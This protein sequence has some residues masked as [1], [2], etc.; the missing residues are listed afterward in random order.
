MTILVKKALRPSAAAAA[1]AEEEPPL[2]LLLHG[3]PDDAS[4]FHA[5]L[6]PFA[7]AGFDVVVP[8]MPGYEPSTALLPPS[9]Y[10]LGALA[11]MVEDVIDWGL[12][13]SFLEKKK[14]EKDGSKEGRE[15]EENGGDKE[16]GE[17]ECK[18]R[19][20]ERKVH[21]LGHDWGAAVAYLLARNG[22]TSAMK[23]ASI[24]TL[25]VPHNPLPAFLAHPGQF[26]NSWYMIFIVS[27][28]PPSSIPRSLPPYIF[29]YSSPSLPPSLPPSPLAATPLLARVLVSDRR[30]LHRLTQTVAGLVA[31][32]RPPSLPPCLASQDVCGA[33]SVG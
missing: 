19:Q 30:A 6:L 28:P 10:G 1:A 4:T 3:F 13:T 9:S 32:V 12:A 2:L 17:K 25:A 7:T 27:T 24:V 5:Q 16:K 29:T 8:I 22:S 23:I 20:G 11:G 33:W 31:W 14:E 15:E 26:V 18:P 21:I